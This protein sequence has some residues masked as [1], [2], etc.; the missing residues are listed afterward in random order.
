MAALYGNADLWKL[1]SPDEAE[2]EEECSTAYPAYAVVIRGQ[3]WASTYATVERAQY[4][5]E[6]FA[7]KPCLDAGEPENGDRC[8]YVLDV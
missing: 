7:C 6:G 2:E 3:R 1:A 8:C 5:W 4:E